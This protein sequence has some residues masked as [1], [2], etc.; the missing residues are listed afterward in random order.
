MYTDSI[1]RRMNVTALL[2]LLTTAGPVAADV[3]FDDVIVWMETYASAP[4]DGLAPGTYT[5]DAITDLTAY[6]APGLIGIMD[7]PEFRIEITPTLTYQPHVS[8]LEATERYIDKASI[9]PSGALIG[10][11]S[12]QPFSAAAIAD[13]P[14]TEA[15]SMVIWNHLYRWQH[16]GYSS[17]IVMNYVQPGT[18]GSVGRKTDGIGGGGDVSRYVTMYYHRVYL[19]GV[20]MLA[21]QDYRV[22]VDD[23]DEIHW[24]EYVKLLDPFDVKGTQFVVERSIDP[25]LG[26]QVNSYLP[27]ERRVR[28]LS[29]KERADHWMGTTFT[30]DEFEGFSARPL[31]YEWTYRGR[32]VIMHV[33]ASKH[34]AAQF[35]GPASNLPDDRWQ[36]RPC[37][38][39]EGA[40]VWEGHPYGRRLVF[41]DANTFTTAL[42]LIFDH[43]D[44]LLN[45]FYT[46]YRQDTD[47]TDPTTPAELTVPRWR[48]SVGI[49]MQGATTS[50]ARGSTAGSYASIS[51]AKVRRV[52]DVSNL[53]S[54]R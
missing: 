46:V 47:G 45:V 48:A 30:F 49:N 34:E 50:I 33:N 38:V 36:L 39:V 42:H 5:A 16:Y 10:Y 12:G 1:R 15:G 14:A 41:F 17:E 37:F 40:P 20:A 28:R 27:T 3:T 9:A 13:A 4:A 21:D 29:A 6:V 32:K 52:F 43:E 11:V 18:P 23:S 24:K 35:F 7:F 31:D 25:E 22:D 2:L 54:G 53:T 19:S 44:R 51:P 26:D 8:Y